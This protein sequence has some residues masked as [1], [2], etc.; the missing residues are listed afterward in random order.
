M[1]TEG[2]LRMAEN[3]KQNPN[4]MERHAQ[5]IIGVVLTAILLWVGATVNSN[6]KTLIKLGTQFDAMQTRLEDF[7]S[8]ANSSFPGDDGRR[9]RERVDKLNESLAGHIQ[10]HK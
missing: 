3:A 9:L 4:G 10:G 1:I 2:F 7:K 6:E 5:T 8:A